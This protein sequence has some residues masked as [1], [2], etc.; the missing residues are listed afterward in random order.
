MVLL[1]GPDPHSIPHIQILLPHL[2][3]PFQGHL[4]SS[5]PSPEFPLCFLDSVRYL[6]LDNK[7]PLPG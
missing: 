2:L 7:A 4:L 6:V 5:F 1:K 3:R